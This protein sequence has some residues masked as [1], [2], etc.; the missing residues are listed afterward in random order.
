MVVITNLPVCL[1]T[2]YQ[3]SQH[4][5]PT[6]TQKQCK[7]CNVIKHA[8]EFCKSKWGVDG[9]HSR[10]AVM[11]CAETRFAVSGTW[12]PQVWGAGVLYAGVCLLC[13]HKL[14]AA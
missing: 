1:T 11:S 13:C 10:C 6:V 14:M 3:I 5:Q 9:L 2:V 8:S 12:Q 4:P 7:K